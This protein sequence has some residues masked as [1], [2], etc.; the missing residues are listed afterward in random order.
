MGG[1]RSFFR[2]GKTVLR[3]ATSNV[4]LGTRHTALETFF[5]FPFY[6]FLTAENAEVLRKERKEKYTTYTYFFGTKKTLGT[7]DSGLSTKKSSFD[8]RHKKKFT[9]ALL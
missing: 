6:L 1:G 5:P 8:L 3:P 4:F 9:F 7:R 2:S